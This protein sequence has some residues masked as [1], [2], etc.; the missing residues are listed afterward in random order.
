MKARSLLAILAVICASNARSDAAPSSAELPDLG[1]APPQKSNLAV[2][3]GP[4]GVTLESTFENQK[5]IVAPEYSNETGASLG[6][7]FAT[8][9][10]QDAAVGVLLNIGNDKKEWLINAGYK[11]DERQRIVVTAGQLKQFLDY[12]F[13][14]GSEKVG[15]TQNSGAVSYQFQLGK[16]FLRF[17]EV[18]GYLSKTAGRDLTDK[19]FAVDTATLFELWN[20]PRRIA[21]GEV[22]GLQ[23]KLGFSPIEGSLIKVSLGDERLR[24]DYF[25]GKDTTHRPTGG[26]EWLQQLPNR[27]NL[28]LSA[29]TFASQN[30]YS[31]GLDH[32]ISSSDSGRHSLGASLNSIQGRGGLGNDTQ[33]NVVYSYVFGTGG[34]AS[35]QN[36]LTPALDTSAP[37]PLTKAFNGELS[38]SGQSGLWSGSSLL[39]Q[40]ALRPSVIPSHVIAKIDTT[41]LPTRL[42]AID[43]TA[44]PVGHS[45]NIATGTITAPTGTPVSGIAGVTK[46]TVPFTNAG[47]FALSGTGLLVVNPRLITHPAVGFT[48]TYVVTMNNSSGG[49]TTLA[50]V[51]VSRG[52]VQI[53]SIV[54]TSTDGSVVSGGLTWTRNNSTVAS[55]GAANWSTANST[56]ATLTAQG[57]AAGSWRL[58]TEAELDALATAN[59]LQN[60]LTTAGW[61]LDFTWTNKAYT[62]NGTYAHNGVMLQAG[63][64]GGNTYRN[65]LDTG[66]VSCAH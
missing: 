48:D 63:A 42:I 26:F 27:F 20:D 37:N 55:P 18:N 21:G 41:V 10:G 19:T 16:E 38:T 64:Y 62:Q 11:L 32:S 49:G 56:C 53:N 51:V 25:T 52:S 23:G 58:P 36:R 34:T 14:S 7:T 29:D 35:A 43:K 57:L 6:A 61:T 1:A 46:N 22:A 45:I 40:V 31:I 47:Q 50:T 2:R 9:L 28:K 13:I 15:L 3:P 65:D 33:V 5:I 39:D 8:L 12:T 54:M 44:M 4:G 30:R 60:N 59:V 66:W 24:Y 17:F